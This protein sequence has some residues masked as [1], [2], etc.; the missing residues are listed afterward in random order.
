[1]EVVVP[2]II[3]VGK[4]PGDTGDAHRAST[5]LVEHAARHIGTRAPERGI[6][7]GPL[8]IRMLD[9][10]LGTNAQQEGDANHDEIHRIESIADAVVH[11]ALQSVRLQ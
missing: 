1:M 3:V 8:R 4:G 9:V 10:A 6:H 2:R 7:L 5:T 11:L